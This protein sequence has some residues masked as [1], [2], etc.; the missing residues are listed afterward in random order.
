MAVL[1]S[2]GGAARIDSNPKQN[3]GGG[4]GV[5]KV[6]GPN[7]NAAAGGGASIAGSALDGTE[8]GA[9]A[10]HALD[11]G[12]VSPE[13]APTPDGGSVSPEDAAPPD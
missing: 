8:A 7:V 6:V 4:N 10:T 2:C 13:D 1:T 9:G 5:A 3:N 11:G 12:S